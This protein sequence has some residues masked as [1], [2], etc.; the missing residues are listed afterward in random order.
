MLLDALMLENQ[1]CSMLSWPLICVTIQPETLYTTPL[2][3]HGLV[4][5]L[6]FKYASTFVNNFN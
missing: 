4:L 2:F 1:L 6:H 3:Q 5:F